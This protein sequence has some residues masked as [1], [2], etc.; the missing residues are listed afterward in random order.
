M[1]YQYFYKLN[2]LYIKKFKKN[3]KEYQEK[4]HYKTANDSAYPNHYGKISAYNASWN[5]V[6][7]CYIYITVYNKNTHMSKKFKGKNKG[8][9]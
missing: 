7:G 4:L 9:F 5:H 6:A 8:F 3:L 1:Y 2:N